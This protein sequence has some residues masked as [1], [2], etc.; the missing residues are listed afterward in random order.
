MVILGAGAYRIS[1]REL[2]KDVRKA[3][4]VMEEEYSIN[5]KLNRNELGGIISSAVADKLEVIRRGKK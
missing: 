3:K 1:S 5:S 4:K 2:R